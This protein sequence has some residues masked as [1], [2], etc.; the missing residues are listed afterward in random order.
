MPRLI[1]HYDR[2][3]ISQHL[4]DTYL[5]SLDDFA[6]REESDVQDFWNDL[7]SYKSGARL[8]FVR[9]FTLALFWEEEREQIELSP[10][11]FRW[12]D[13]AW[14]EGNQASG[15]E[16][17][18]DAALA[19]HKAIREGDVQ[20]AADLFVLMLDEFCPA[21]FSLFL[22]DRGKFQVGEEDADLAAVAKKLCE[23]EHWNLPGAQD[24]PGWLLDE[25]L[26]RVLA[27]S[28]QQWAREMEKAKRETSGKAEESSGQ[29]QDGLG[30]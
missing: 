21:L 15:A 20:R 7:Y 28:A 30:L 1:S 5:F 11:A 4:A 17:L 6:T 27:L 26:P 22:F 10:T 12:L 9:R 3:M 8:P 25:F 13:S 18:N 2:D 23:S 19:F 29:P 16:L 14:L 24:F